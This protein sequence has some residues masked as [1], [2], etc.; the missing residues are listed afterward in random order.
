MIEQGAHVSGTSRSQSGADALAAQK[1]APIIFVDIADGILREAAQN[2]DIILASIPPNDDTDPSF[3]ALRATL[4]AA[5][6]RWIAY[7]STTG[8]YG[9]RQGGWAFEEDAPSPLSIEAKRRV[10]AERAWQSLPSPAHI[11]RL[12][13]IYGPSRSALDQVLSG[14]ARRIDRAGQVFS[15]AHRDD[16]VSA[17]LAS[18]E[19]PN[20]GRIYNICD[21]RPCA[22][23]EVIVEACRLLGVAPPPL[24]PFA[25]AG[26][27]EMGR[28]FYSECKRVSNARIK[29]ELGWR[30]RFA[31]YVEGLADCLAARDI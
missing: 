3:L 7:L 1:I 17:L 19:K 20:P 10:A 9:D 23:G 4:G 6:P 13:G 14:N 24:L 31:T 25:A 28:R 5:K 12:P 26:L 22:S 8:V 11:F 29:A 2:S 16:I 15:R 30:P 18:I 21:D 27:S